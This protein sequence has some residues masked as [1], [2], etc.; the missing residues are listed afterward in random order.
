ME[1]VPYLDQIIPPLV[2]AFRKY[3]KNNLRIL[4]DAIGTLADNVGH[5]L[6]DPKYVQVRPPLRNCCVRRRV[7][8]RRSN[9]RVQLSHAVFPSI[10]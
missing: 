6:N 4:Y 7:A 2:E 9:E 10:L 3:Q 1:L 5:F 8:I